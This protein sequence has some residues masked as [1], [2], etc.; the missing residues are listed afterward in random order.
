M[1]GY[2]K[3]YLNPPP[4]PSCTGGNKSINSCLGELN[5]VNF[6]NGRKWENILSFPP[7]PFPVVEDGKKQ[8]HGKAIK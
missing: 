7:P 2:V 6:R 4:F 1:G 5:Q 3:I 8:L